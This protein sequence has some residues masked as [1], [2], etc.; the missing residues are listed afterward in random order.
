MKIELTEREVK[1]F[2]GA[3]D[4]VKYDIYF[5]ECAILTSADVKPTIAKLEKA[6]MNIKRQ[7]DE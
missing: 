7:D 1:M 3:L 6:I 4:P 5:E 2:L